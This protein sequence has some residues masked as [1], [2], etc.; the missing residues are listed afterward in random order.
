MEVV[1]P[2]DRVRAEC[3]RPTCAGQA[4]LRLETRVSGFGGESR[5]RKALSRSSCGDRRPTGRHACHTQK[6]GV[7][8]TRSHVSVFGETTTRDCL[9]LLEEVIAASAFHDGRARDAQL[10][11]LSAEDG[12]WGCARARRALYQADLSPASDLL[13]LAQ[14][15]KHFGLQ[16]RA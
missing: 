3:S 14:S 11:S 8:P 6:T 12:P 2:H 1:V 13:A 9:L 5:V 10:G 16:H 7:P 4:E 15:M